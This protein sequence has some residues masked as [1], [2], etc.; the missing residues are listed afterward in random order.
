MSNKLRRH[1]RQEFASK[2]WLTWDG[3]GLLKQSACRGLDISVS[4]M[5]VASTEPIPA[6][7]LV[8]FRVQGTMFVGAGSI[9][10]CTHERMRYAIGVE[11]SQGV[12]WDP[13]RYPISVAQSTASMPA[14][15]P[16]AAEPAK[17][18]EAILAVEQ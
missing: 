17:T 16:V 9:R 6:G 8:N 18:E 15:Q 13:E 14:Y 5:R 4:G 1:I 2:V 11:F 12:R 7:T 10:S 3:G